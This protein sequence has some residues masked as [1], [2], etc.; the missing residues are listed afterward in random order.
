MLLVAGLLAENSTY[1]AALCQAGLLQ[2]LLAISSEPELQ[3]LSPAY[4]KVGSTTA[5]D[6]MFSI[7]LAPRHVPA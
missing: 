1:R 3:E 6:S 5:Q 4:F 2:T 7:L